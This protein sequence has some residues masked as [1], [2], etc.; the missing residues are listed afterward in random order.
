M[1]MSM[2]TCVCVCV[3]LS[4]FLSQRSK[5]SHALQRITNEQG[6]VWMQC[7]C[8]CVCG[9]PWIWSGYDTVRCM[10]VLALTELQSTGCEARDSNAV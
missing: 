6:M 9:V 2:S 3:Y 7:V 1:C 10:I 4:L 5:K 8:V